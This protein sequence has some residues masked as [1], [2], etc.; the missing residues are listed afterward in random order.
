MRRFEVTNL[1]HIL[2]AKK[3]CEFFMKLKIVKYFKITLIFY[4][5]VIRF[6]GIMT[7]SFS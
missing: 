2:N 1:M 3:L 6:S 7:N 5:K 4:V